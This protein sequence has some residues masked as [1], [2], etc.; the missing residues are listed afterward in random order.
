MRKP[1]PKPKNSPLGPQNVKNDPKIK[2]KIPKPYPKPKNSPFRPKKKSKMTP[3]SDQNQK[4]ELK[5]TLKIKVFQLHEPT[6]KQFV[7]PTPTPKIG[8]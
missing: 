2:P 8:H 5:K 3:K 1:Y 4:L 6:P 7:N